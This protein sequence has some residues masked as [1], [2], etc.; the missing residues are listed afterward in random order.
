MLKPELEQIAEENKDKAVYVKIDVE[1]N[2]EVA[3]EYAIESLPTV[4]CLKNKEKVG[5]M[6]G[7]KVENFKKFMT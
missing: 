1:E 2:E 6:K 7:S 4:I 5:E 3:E